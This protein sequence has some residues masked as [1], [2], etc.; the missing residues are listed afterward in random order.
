MLVEQ[1]KAEKLPERLN[2]K[3]TYLVWLKHYIIPKWGDSRISDLQAR[4]VELWIETLELAPKSKAHVRSI[5]RLLWDYA[6]WAGSVPVQRNPMELVTVKG[7]TKRVHKP[8]S[9][10]VAEFHKFIMHLAEPFRTLA[11]LSVCFG[12]RISEALALKWAD[13]DW[14][15]QTLNI[16]RRIVSQHIDDTKTEESQR[17]M[18]VDSAVLEVLKLWKQTT[19]FPASHDWI[20]ASPTSLGRLPWSYAQVWDYYSY[21]SRDAGIGHVSTHVLRHTYRS[22]L[23]AAGTSIAVQQ[24]MM[25]HADIRTTLNIY[26]DVVTDEMAQA[27][28]KI[29]RF[30]INGLP[31][32]CKAS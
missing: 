10:T 16:E 9:L 20:F 2:T 19:Q 12:L 11:I 3:R 6:M 22:W 26:G 32:D 7:A 1:Y 27:G 8:R 23:D 4:P 30:A 14:F 24:K 5:V 29:A 18:A 21:A 17:K 25:R 15:A 13:V 31:A 28:S